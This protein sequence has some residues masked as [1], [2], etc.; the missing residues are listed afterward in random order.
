MNGKNKRI[1]RMSNKVMP[2]RNRLD[3]IV[4]TLS[5]YYIKNALYLIE[6]MNKTYKELGL[7]CDMTPEA[8]RA[9]KKDLGFS[10]NAIYQLG[11]AK[12]C[13]EGLVRSR[14][15]VEQELD[16]KA[17]TRTYDLG[18]A[19]AF[20]L[21]SID[22]L[23]MDVTYTDIANANKVHNYFKKYKLDPNVE[24]AYKTLQQKYANLVRGFRERNKK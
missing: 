11:Q 5:Y 1:R 14:G 15:L 2:E 18:Q 19:D 16:S 12:R 10:S 21:L 13:Y 17:F 20:D 6:V 23:Y 9:L 8:K 24:D 3:D 22:F 4:C 7:E